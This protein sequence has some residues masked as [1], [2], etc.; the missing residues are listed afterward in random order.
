M[1]NKIIAIGI[2]LFAICYNFWLYRS[3]PT[4]KIDPNDN[5]FQYALVDR[6][7]QMWDFALKECPKNPTFPIC[8]GGYLIDHIVPNWA[9]G[10]SLPY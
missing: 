7:N 9:Q 2:L 5:P 3:E 4:A 6:T 1:I 8:F 10:Y